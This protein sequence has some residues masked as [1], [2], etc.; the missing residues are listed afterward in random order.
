MNEKNGEYTIRDIARMSGLSIASISRYFN[1]LKVRRSTAQ[2]IENTL[3][4]I[5]YKPNIAAKYMKGQRTGVIGLIVPEISHPFFALIAEGVIEEARRN[6]QLILIS[7]SYG[8]RENEIIAIDQFSRSILDGLIYIPV[9]NPQNIPAIESFR[10][11][12]LVVAARANIFAHVPHVYSDNEKGGYLATKFLIRQNRRNIAFLGSF[13]EIPCNVQDIGNM[14]NAANAGSFSTISRFKGYLRALEEEGIVYDPNKVFLCGYG[15][16]NGYDAA[17]EV[18]AKLTDVDGVIVMTSTVANGAVDAFR[19]HGISVPE[20]IS[21]VVFDDDEIMYT[22]LPHFTTV[23]LSLR[24]MG[25]EAVK[26]LNKILSH[27]ECPDTVIDV[28]L[29]I[30]D[31]TVMKE[32]QSDSWHTARRPDAQEAFLK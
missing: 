3:K 27:K 25:I 20:T 29:K 30:G 23:Q 10:N 22:T 16:Q 21:L 2:K 19:T 9:S 13:W 24:K 26:S 18:M 12:P 15:Y 17:R 8:S 1:G 11:I 6:D 4:F 7:S 28:R 14:T 31:S 32:I 5:D